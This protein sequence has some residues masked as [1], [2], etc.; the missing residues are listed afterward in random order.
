MSASLRRHALVVLLILGAGA[1]A[2]GLRTE[3]RPDPALPP[4]AALTAGTAWQ[5]D[6]AYQPGSA[7]IVFRQWLLR[8]PDGVEA[9]LYVGA[10][11]HAKAVVGWDGERGYLGEGYLVTGRSQATVRLDGG[12][13]APVSRVLVQRLS[14]RRL[15]AY[16]VVSPDGVFASGTG[17]PLRIAWDAVSAR[18]GPY[19]LVRVSLPATG[20]A[21]ASADRLLAAVIPALGAVSRTGSCT[22]SGPA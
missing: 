1:A 17:S 6:T 20:L 11:A 13:R 15:L 10:T 7:G 12:R 5:V 19:Y 16:A 9:L 2:A 21:S 8:D 3:G 18:G 4:V 14:D 22:C